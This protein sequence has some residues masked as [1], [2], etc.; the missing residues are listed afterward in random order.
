MSRIGRKP[1]AIPTGVEV[2]IVDQS[3]SVK[4][5]K[6][7][8]KLHVHPKMTV[9]VAG[10][11]LTVKRPSDQNPFRALHGTLRSH[12]MNMVVGVT[13]GYEKVL[14]INGVGFR[15]ALQGREL[16]LSLGF[17]H[18]INVPLPKGVDAQVDKQT[19]V[20][21]RGIDRRL[22]GQVAADIRGL[23]PPEPYKGKGIKY[24]DEHI[25]RKEGKTGK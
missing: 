12:L 20:T 6:G 16:V 22:V 3:I 13:K 25:L 1:I 10:K 8:L 9:E 18:P 14:E 2:H 21:L 19:I 23:R 17:S 5:P 7:E 24:K 11:E 15:A 4:G